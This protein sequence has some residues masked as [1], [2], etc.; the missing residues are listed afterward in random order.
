M[1]DGGN[2]IY[3]DNIHI[4]DVK[5]T[6]IAE[7]LQGEVSVYPN[8]TQG[9]IL[10]SLTNEASGQ[11]QVVVS[12]FLGRTMYERTMNKYGALLDVRLPQG[13]LKAGIYAITVTQEGRGEQTQTLVVR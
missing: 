8:P 13:T 10:I 1:S 3:L 4:D 12:D 11:V 6:A 5:I 7:Q 9:E 2:N